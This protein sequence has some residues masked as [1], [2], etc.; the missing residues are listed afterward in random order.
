MRPA[1]I[2]AASLFLPTPAFAASVDVV[3][4]GLDNPRGL[5]FDADGLLYV[6]EG[7][8]GGTTSTE[9]QCEQVVPPARHRAAELV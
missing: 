1:L 9:G 2:L 7:G 3:M 4:S 5:K 6:A 8:Q